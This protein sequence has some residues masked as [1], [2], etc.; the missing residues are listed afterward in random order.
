PVS[1]VAP[2][3]LASTFAT[4]LVGAS[5]FALLS[6][7]RS[8]RGDHRAPLPAVGMTVAERQR[9]AGAVGRRSASRGTPVPA[10]DQ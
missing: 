10:A 1:Q 3:A 4:S 5:T 6:D 2:A 7:P 9:R 8:G